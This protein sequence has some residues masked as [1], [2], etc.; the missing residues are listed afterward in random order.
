M[1]LHKELIIS[2]SNCDGRARSVLDAKQ[3]TVLTRKALNVVG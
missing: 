1:E 3:L 2:Q